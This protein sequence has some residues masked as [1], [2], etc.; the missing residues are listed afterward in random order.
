MTERV[1]SNPFKFNV[2]VYMCVCVCMCVC[3]HV[4]GCVC[5]CIIHLCQRTPCLCKRALHLCKEP[6]I[7]GKQ[8]PKK[9]LI[10]GGARR[11]KC[12]EPVRSQKLHERSLRMYTVTNIKNQYSLLWK[13]MARLWKYRA[14]LR[15]D[16]ALY[17]HLPIQTPRTSELTKITQKKPA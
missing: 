10:K 5:M 15:K 13:Y 12:R 7:C 9:H 8:R 16:R 2:Y 3:V 6:Y 17:C 1:D 4:C 11:F 14:L